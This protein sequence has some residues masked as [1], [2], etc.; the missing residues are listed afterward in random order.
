MT[1]SAISGVIQYA[2]L[3]WLFLLFAVVLI[4]ML[5]GD[6]NT[7]GLLTTTPDGRLNPERVVLLAA[8]IG[9]LAGYALQTLSTEICDPTTGVCS[10]PEPPDSL[11][12][13]FAGANGIYLSGKLT[14]LNG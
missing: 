11:L 7:T 10:M 14:R 2:V 9:A 8:T 12:V 3:P 4:R 13:L 1:P 6:I 5:R